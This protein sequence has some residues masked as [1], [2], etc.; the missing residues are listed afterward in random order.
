MPQR[1]VGC[2]DLYTVVLAISDH[3][4][5]DCIFNF[6]SVLSEPLRNS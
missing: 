1:D 6:S 2:A 4:G 5:H 3:D